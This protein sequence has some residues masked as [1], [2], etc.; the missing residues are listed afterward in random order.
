[1]FVQFFACVVLLALYVVV[2]AMLCV[3]LCLL[4]VVVCVMLW[5]FSYAVLRVCCAV[6]GCCDCF[7]WWRVVM[8]CVAIC[9]LMLLWLCFVL[10]VHV[11]VFVSV[12]LLDRGVFDWC[13]VFVACD[14]LFWL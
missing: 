11:F 3:L 7:V 13:F 9:C 10:R 4:F 6:F 12:V 5:L 2:C 14:G 8:F 1:M